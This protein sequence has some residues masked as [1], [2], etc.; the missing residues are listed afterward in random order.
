LKEGISEAQ[1]AS[2]DR[3]KK[4][5]GSSNIEKWNEIWAILFPEIACPK[6]PCKHVSFIHMAAMLIWL[7]YDQNLSDIPSPPPSEGCSQFL[8]LFKAILDHKIGQQHIRLEEGMHSRVVNAVQVAFETWYRTFRSDRGFSSTDS[9][10]ALQ[11]SYLDGSWQHVTPSGPSGTHPMS[12]NSQAYSM[13]IVGSATGS[14]M[15]RPRRIQR[16]NAVHGMDHRFMAPPPQYNPNDIGAGMPAGH[17]S[18]TGYPVDI[19]ANMDPF[20]DTFAN[21]HMEAGTDQYFSMDYEAP[22]VSFDDADAAARAA[23][24]NPTGGINPNQT[25]INSPGNAAHHNLAGYPQNNWPHQYAGPR[26]SHYNGGRS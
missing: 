9:S 22:G 6:T 1:W 20:G 3:K 23:F 18:H 21:N 5:Q 10:S 12:A 26:H 14:S 19:Q 2:L 13:D 15:M 4:N 16:D 11:T 25:F 17:R 24:A 7:G 8:E